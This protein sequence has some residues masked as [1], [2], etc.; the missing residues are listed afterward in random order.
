[1]RRR[2]R[3]PG[4]PRAGA[5]CPRARRLAVSRV[6]ALAD[7]S[8]SYSD[9]V[10]WP[11]GGT[12]L[13]Q[14]AGQCWRTRAYGDFWSHLLVAEGAVDIAAEPDLSVWDVAALVPVVLEAGGR[15]TGGTGGSVL[16]GGGAVTTNGRLHDAAL[17]VLR[18]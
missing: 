2:V 14:L 6:S 12:G 4:S 5:A 15:I 8:L 9:T 1:M 10:G 3:T 7:A 18:G 11:D 16:D 17:R 13:A